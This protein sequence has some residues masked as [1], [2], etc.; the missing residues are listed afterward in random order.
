MHPRPPIPSCRHAAFAA[1]F[2]ALTAC[3]KK[4][5]NAPWERGGH[6]APE[7]EEMS[8]F[9]GDQR[10]EPECRS[11]PDAAASAAISSCHESRAET[12]RG[13]QRVGPGGR[14]TDAP[15]LYA[16][17]R[18][19]NRIPPPGSR[20]PSRARI[21]LNLHDLY[22]WAPRPPD[23]LSDQRKQWLTPRL[24]P[25]RK[26]GGQPDLSAKKMCLNSTPL[27]LRFRPKR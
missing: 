9:R 13:L 2:A 18:Q 14:H 3:L 6:W 11:D 23:V 24:L 16:I 7:G 20:V 8:R 1:T 4:V 27:C 19:L 5:R 26:G 17:R 15:F 12:R 21:N 22:S 25:P 10:G